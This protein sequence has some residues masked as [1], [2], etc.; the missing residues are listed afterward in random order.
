[1]QVI[2]IWD[3]TGIGAA[4][5]EAP[6][7]Y[8]VHEDGYTLYASIDS[9]V[10]LSKTLEV[11]ESTT[12]L[13][14]SFAGGCTYAIGG[15]GLYATLLNSE[16]NWVDVCGLPCHVREDLSDYQYAI[17]EVP[18]LATTYSI[19]NYQIVESKTLYGTVFPEDT[20]LYDD[21]TQVSYEPSGDECSFGMTMLEGHVGV[22]DEAKIF[23]NFLSSKTPYVN[24]LFF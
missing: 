20:V 6:E 9:A 8:F 10:E 14:C 13:E 11:T 4:S 7:L 16:N 21:L 15:E 22:L 2:G 23:I 3:T 19:D 1:M 24:N 5:D 17:C 18:E 12:D